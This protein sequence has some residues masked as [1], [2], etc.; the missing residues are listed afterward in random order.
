VN[1]FQRFFL[2]L[3]PSRT[4]DEDSKLKRGHIGTRKK[5]TLVVPY[6]LRTSI[7][8]SASPKEIGITLNVPKPQYTA[9]FEN[10]RAT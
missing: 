10:F 1:D 6:L 7:I 5:K 2:D 9:F 4:A 3:V 8:L